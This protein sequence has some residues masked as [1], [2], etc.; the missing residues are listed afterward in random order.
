MA[1]PL[2]YPFGIVNV[3]TA[4]RWMHLSPD[5]DGAVWMLNLMKYKA[6]ADYGVALGGRMHGAAVDRHLPI[7]VVRAHLALEGG[8]VRQR[9]ANPDTPPLFNGTGGAPRPN[10]PWP[11]GCCTARWRMPS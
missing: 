10:M 4:G 5:E 9:V 3:E 2:E 1:N 7:H 11:P 6:V 8:D